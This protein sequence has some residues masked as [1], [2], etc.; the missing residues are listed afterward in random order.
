MT[1]RLN[2]NNVEI[3][4]VTEAQ[5]D[6]LT[7]VVGMMVY[8]T[9][10]G[11][12][13]QVEIWDGS[14][15]R[16]TDGAIADA[17]NPLTIA[18]TDGTGGSPSSSSIAATVGEVFELDSAS[19]TAGRRAIVTNNSGGTV[20]FD[21]YVWSGGGKEGSGPGPGGGSAGHGMNGRYSMTNGS[22]MTLFAAGAS[23]SQNGRPFPDGGL[24]SPYGGASPGGGSSR[25]MQGSVPIPGR[26][27]TPRVSLLAA[28]GGGG[29]CNWLNSGPRQ[30]YGGY[31]DG[32]RG[33]FYY[34]AEPAQADGKGG[35]QN[36]G[37][38]GGASGRQPAGQ[39]G[40]KYYG[41][42]SSNVGGAG[43]GGGWYGGGGSGGYYA[44]GGG[45]SGYVHPNVTFASQFTSSPGGNNHRSVP[46]GGPS[47][48][49]KGNAGNSN[50]G[51]YIAIE[52]YS[53]G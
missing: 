8:N 11:S 14:K 13:G 23:T 22:E 12:N 53:V 46:G 19:N 35:T 16:T 52:V 18:I 29:G 28:G 45:G 37:G 5:R 40:A 41:G 15:W 49:N 27:D 34:P 33:N 47:G 4:Q 26:N 32:F 25:V 48:V 2:S 20:T 7:A 3:A 39:A 31:P 10:G 9:E 6:A 44:Q 17:L 38:A 43:G 1:T 51:G 21:M 50:N 24:S 30:G 36:A 42:T